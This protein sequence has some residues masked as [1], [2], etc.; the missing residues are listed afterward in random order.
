MNEMANLMNG[1]EYI[2]TVAN[3]KMRIRSAQHRAALSVN[4]ELIIL[5]WNIG[6]AINE[7]MLWGSSFVEN[8]SRDIRS[9][10]PGTTGYSVRNLNY[11]VKFARTYPDLEFVQTVSAKLPWSHNITLLDKVKDAVQREWYARKTIDSGWSIDVLVHQIESDLYKRRVTTPK[12]SNFEKRLPAPQSELA[13][14]QMNDLYVFSFIQNGEDILEHEIEN[15]LTRNITKFLLEL[16]TGFAFIGRQYHLEVGGEDFYADL[17][18]YNTNLSCYVVVELKKGTFK[19]EYVGKLNFYLSAIDD[20]LKK[21]KDNPTI[22][23]LLCKSKNNIVAEYSLRDISKPMGI[24]EY[25][26]A[27]KMPEGYEDF[28]PTAED[29]ER[30]IILNMN[31]DGSEK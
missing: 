28:L 2:S 3:I 16:G 25:R 31:D 4:S 15:E 30:G 29:I 10:F 27:G 1:R 14:Q 26:L 8:L 12:V 18:F 11:M 5:Y 7:N 21:E 24:S 13:L 17:L 19:P 20:I 23:I 6:C 9:D 22:G